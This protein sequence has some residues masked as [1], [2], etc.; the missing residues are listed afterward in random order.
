MDRPVSSSTQRRQKTGR[1]LRI[2]LIILAVIAGVWAFRYFLKPTADVREL[3]IATVEQGDMKNTI[4]ATGLV[5]AAFEE[6]LNAPVSTTIKKLH[7]PTGQQVKPGDLILSLDREYVQLDLNSRNDQLSLKKNNVNLLKLEYDRDIK[8]LD[9]N[10]DIKNLELSSAEAQLADAK[11]L[12]TIGGATAEEVERA[13]LSVQIIRL[14]R[15]KLANEL[16]YREN[17]LAGRRRNL[18]LEVGIQEKEVTQ[19]SRKLR[20]TEVRAPRAG[21]VTWINENIGQQVVEGAPLVRIAD[22][23]KF[24]ME[25]SCSDRYADQLAVGLPVE[26]ELAKGNKITGMV[27][28]ILPEVENNTLKF[29]IAFDDPANAGLRPNLRAQVEVIAGQKSDVLRVKRGPAFRGGVRQDIF[30]VRGEEAVSTDITL[31]MRNGDYIEITAGVQAGDR[32]IISD[33][34][35]YRNVQRFTLN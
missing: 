33:V 4:T 14:E 32:I 31:G 5:I 26:I 28:S 22:L 35:A 8:E 11:R 30:V 29:M 3:R 20:E 24:R 12:L 34:A 7:L 19:L 15:D 17:S 6:Q 16:T 21:V 23:G 27:S 10:T 18:E 2:G 13:A 1:Y 9:Y 25:G